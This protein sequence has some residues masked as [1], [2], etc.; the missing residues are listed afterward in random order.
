MKWPVLC[1]AAMVVATPTALFAS[2]ISIDISLGSGTTITGGAK[3]A[4]VTWK[5]NNTGAT[6]S[7]TTDGSGNATMPSANGSGFDGYTV[8]V[9]GETWSNLKLGGNVNIISDSEK[10]PAPDH[11]QI[12]SF[13]DVF[14]DLDLLPAPSSPGHSYNT[15]DIRNLGPNN[16]Y[17]TDLK[18]YTDLPLADFT[19]SA[20]DSP[21]AIAAGTL[22]DDVSGRLGPG[23]LASGDAISLSASLT[24][25]DSY[26]LLTMTAEQVL[27]TGGYGPPVDV[28]FGA[29]AVPE[30]ASW[31]MLL[32]GL[33]LLGGALR[34]PGVGLK[35]RRRARRGHGWPAARR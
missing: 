16:Y 31:T 19:L 7:T 33:F 10:K 6:A 8:T 26:A 22:Y 20:F 9:G 5:D 17:I 1:V 13:F 25:D 24:P 30:P 28:A 34:S 27:P 15:F 32:G 14:I 12:H 4:N 11:F 3:N 29:T 21:A 35:A 23:A 18:L 2:T